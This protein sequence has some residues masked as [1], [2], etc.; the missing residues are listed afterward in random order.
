MKK[1]SKSLSLLLMGSLTVA[2]GGC[3]S[4]DPSEEFR[5]YNSIDECVNEK[6]FSQ[7][8]CREMAIAA[9]R[10]N[11]KFS[12]VEECEK[13]FGA[14]QCQ[15]A[16]EKATTSGE[17]RSS[18]MPLIAGYMAGRYLSGGNMMQSAQPLYQQPGQG[19]Q[20]NAR[21]YRTLGGNSVQADAKGVVNKP[22]SAIRN[23]FSKSAKP[24]AV[25]SGG[26]SSRSG[27]SG[28]KASS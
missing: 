10:Q 15:A 23:G 1:A 4:D 24:M 28:G 22:S 21:T 9:V 11:P 14:G 17:R 7:A 25:R 13:E 19:Q 18:W 2:L 27:F 3:G 5:T 16:E 12:S 8:E 26:S 20:G 6:L